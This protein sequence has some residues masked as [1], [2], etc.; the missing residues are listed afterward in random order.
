M[1]AIEVSTS[2]F[3]VSNLYKSFFAGTITVLCFKA[4]G[5]IAIAAVFTCDASYF[6]SGFG[7]VGINHEQPFFI[8]LGLLCGIGGSYYIKFQRWVNLKKKAGAA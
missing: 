3:S 4:V 8:I 7:A 2:S 5:K 1:F 6:Y